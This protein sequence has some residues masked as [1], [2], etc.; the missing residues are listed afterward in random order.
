MLEQITDQDIRSQVET[1]LLNDTQREQ[2]MQQSASDTLQPGTVINRIRI[3]KLLGQGG[4]G[5][6]YLGFD[7]KLERQV[8]IKS[9]RP[10]HLKNPATQQRFEREAQILSKINHPSICQLYDYL[11]TDGGDF[12]VLEY[13]QGKPL[14]QVPLSETQKLSALAELAAALAVAHEHGIVH[15]DLKPEV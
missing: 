12:L 14:Y 2:F 4:M 13:I 5:S 11:E 3:E 10:E 15:R 1:L 6:V 9:I 7:E 8:A